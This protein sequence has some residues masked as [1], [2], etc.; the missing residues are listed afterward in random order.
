MS[1]ERRVLLELCILTAMVMNATSL[2][3]GLSSSS[4]VSVNV[5][6]LG[7]QLGVVLS[8]SQAANSFMGTGL[9]NT[10]EGLLDD[11]S[12]MASDKE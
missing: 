12:P 6:C 1:L 7:M 11:L 3:S 10:A 4:L 5:H 8:T 2:P 9:T